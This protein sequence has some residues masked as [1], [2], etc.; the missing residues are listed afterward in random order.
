MKVELFRNLPLGTRFR[1]PGQPEIWVVLDRL[2]HDYCGLVI[3][4]KGVDG[5]THGQSICSATDTPQECEQLKVEVVEP[6]QHNTSNPNLHQAIEIVQHRANGTPGIPHTLPLEVRDAMRTLCQTAHDYHGLV[7]AIKTNR[8]TYILDGND[9]YDWGLTTQ[10]EANH[11]LNEI[12]ATQTQLQTQLEE[13]CLEQARLN[14]KGS[15]REARLQTQNRLLKRYLKQA[16]DILHPSNDNPAD[17]ITRKLIESI[18][19]ILED[20]E[21]HKS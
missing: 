20:L 10:M 8:L 16:K 21:K 9:L 14:G 17:P 4:W 2:G 1:Y 13:E 6:T 3:Q 18:E 7:T 12:Q 19:T 15:E 11:K 5:P